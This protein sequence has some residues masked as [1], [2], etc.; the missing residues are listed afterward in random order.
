MRTNYF[1]RRGFTLIELMVVIVILA[2]LAAL[3]T[4]AVMGAI[5]KAKETAIELELDQ[6]AGAIESYKAKY[7]S[8]P[9]FDYSTGSNQPTALQKHVQSLFPRALPGDINTIPRNLTPPEILWF[10][11]RGY[12]SDPQRPVDFFN[13]NQLKRDEF[14]TFEEGRLGATRRVNH[15][16]NA[17]TALPRNSDSSQAILAYVPVTSKPINERR[18]YVYFDCSRPYAPQLQAYSTSAGDTARPYR[19]APNG[20]FANAGKFQIISAGLD[21]D[22]GVN[23][24]QP[25]DLDN[26]KV[27]PDGVNYSDSGADG[28]NLV[29]FSDRNL[30]NSKP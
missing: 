20:N 1:N 8:Y 11:I 16:S 3:V 2:I 6:L 13:D 26:H 15:D 28:D 23:I 19:T 9:P 24:P 21:D 4:R 12:T 22:Y 7:G 10:C 27:F 14:F 5:T 18:P 17:M 29:N 25:N 30:E